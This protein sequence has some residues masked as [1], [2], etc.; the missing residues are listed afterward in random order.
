MGRRN[1][2]FLTIEEYQHLTGASYHTVLKWIRTGQVHARK[3][4][5]IWQIYDIPDTFQYEFSVSC[6]RPR[7]MTAK[8]QAS[9]SKDD[10]SWKCT[11]DIYC[12]EARALHFDGPDDMPEKGL[13]ALDAEIYAVRFVLEEA[14]RQRISDLIIY[15]HNESIPR[16]ID[17]FSKY[18]GYAAMQESYA[19]LAPACRISFVH[20]SVLLSNI[21]INPKCQEAIAAFNLKTRR[22][23]KDYL[24]LKT[25]GADGYSVLSLKEL[26]DM[27]DDPI[28]VIISRKI[29]PGTSQEARDRISAA[30]LRWYLRGLTPSCAAI[31]ATIDSDMFRKQE[32]SSV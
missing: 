31:K 11:G 25:Y 2:E 32:K 3:A 4:G 18:P 9:F 28:Q 21:K 13:S 20:G 8:L 5:S 26:K 1:G 22:T 17:H 27:V 24:E 23:K 7:K 30:A 15:Y 12:D 14:K 29:D 10:N 6:I 16:V 19:R